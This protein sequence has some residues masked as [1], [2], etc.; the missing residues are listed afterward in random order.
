MSWEDKVEERRKAYGSP[1]DEAKRLAQMYTVILGFPVDP[2]QIGLLKSCDKIVRLAHSYHED[3]PDDLHGYA[4]YIK[5]V[6]EG[7]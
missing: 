7:E 5:E 4:N 3:G 1:I 2:Y 6:A